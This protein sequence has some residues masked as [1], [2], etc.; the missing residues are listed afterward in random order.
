MVRKK[1]INRKAGNKNNLSH[2]SNKGKHPGGRPAI[3][4]DWARVDRMCHI[5]CTGEEI[6]AVLEINYNTLI[7]AVKE[8]F[9]VGFSEYYEEKKAGGRMSLRRRQ[10]KAAVH[11]G[12]PTM[13]IWAGKQYLDQRDKQSTELSGPKGKAIK[14]SQSDIDLSDFT[15]SELAVLEKLGLQKNKAKEE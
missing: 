1:S 7:N 9:G 4:I 14:I 13:L 11:D 2:R 10:W 5:Q 8:K 6:A 15:D 12:N 3:E